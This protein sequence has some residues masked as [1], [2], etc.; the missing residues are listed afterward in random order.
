MLR[1][2]GGDEFVS[3]YPRI[4]SLHTIFLGKRFHH[5]LDGCDIRIERDLP[6]C[7]CLCNQSF[8]WLGRREDAWSHE[9]N[10]YQ[11]HRELL[12]LFLLSWVRVSIII[13]RD[14][15]VVNFPNGFGHLKSKVRYPWLDLD[16]YFGRVGSFIEEALA[17]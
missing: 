8:L 5:R 16:Y 17:E 7:L 13:S 14:P 1:G 3:R 12:H 11:Y 9:A 10:R 2:N 15:G 6:F 4:L